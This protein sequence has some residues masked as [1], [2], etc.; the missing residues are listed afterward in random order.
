MKNN[1]VFK[2][3]NKLANISKS[4]I[5]KEENHDCVVQAIA[6]ATGKDYD[7]V[8]AFCKKT[9][10]REDKKGVTAEILIPTLQKM[11]K[12]FDQPLK[13]IG[14]KNETTGELE[15]KTKYPWKEKVGDKIENRVTIRSMSF[16]TFLKLNPVG[17]FILLVRNH[18]FVLQDG[19]VIGNKWDTAEKR[20]IQKAFQVGTI[21]V[22]P[23]NSK[24]TENVLKVEKPKTTKTEKVEVVKEETA[25][26]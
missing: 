25:T 15:L 7:E 17:T 18:A 5:A 11:K 6:A 24:P 1:I 23:E 22:K 3:T 12:L 2:E 26:I 9:F 13:E 8:H 19:V 10:N 14:E 21:N 16:K 20:I 4:K